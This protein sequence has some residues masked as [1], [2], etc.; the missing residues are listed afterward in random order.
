VTDAPT[1]DG[2]Y[3]YAVSASRL[4]SESGFASALIALSDRTPPPAPLPM[5]ITSK[6]SFIRELVEMKWESLHGTIGCRHGRKRP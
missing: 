3:A 6:Y 4:G 1:N 2:F 5:M